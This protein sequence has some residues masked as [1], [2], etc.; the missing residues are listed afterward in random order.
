MM[1]SRKY[2]IVD[3]KRF[4]VFITFLFVIFSLLISLIITLPRVHSSI[5]EQ[6]FE[7]YHVADGDSLWNISLKYLPK[8][9]DV[10]KMIFEIRELN[11]ME[12]SYI[13]AGETIKIPI[14]NK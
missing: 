6:K 11:D 9:Y 5:Q 2:V 14:Y 13:Y 12:D 7:E 4:F 8:D 3:S 1:K 10:R